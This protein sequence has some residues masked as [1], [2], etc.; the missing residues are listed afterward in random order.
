D[1][2]VR[3]VRTFGRGDEALRA[4]G[5]RDAVQGAEVRR[6]ALPGAVQQRADEELVRAIRAGDDLAGP[7]SDGGQ[8]ESGGD[9]LAS[10]EPGELHD[11][12]RGAFEHEPRGLV[13][14]ADVVLGL[15]HDELTVLAFED[16]QGGVLEDDGEA[17][18]SRLP[19]G[20]L[21]LRD[22]SLVGAL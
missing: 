21:A 20:E 6:G 16:R 7:A 9:A 13:D 18:V 12:W 4:L 15:R 5:G 22:E 2:V 14:A 8:V 1:F 3:D 11:V 17:G 19:L 10:E